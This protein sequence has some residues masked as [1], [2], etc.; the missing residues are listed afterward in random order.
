M[1]EKYAVVTGASTGLGKEIA[2]NIASRG[3]NTILVAL[4]GEN[5]KDVSEMC[6]AKGTDSVCFELDLTDFNAL[7]E[8]TDSINSS[9]KVFALIN[10]AGFGGSS[11]L[12]KVPFDYIRTMI[13]LNAGAT[14]L[15]T[16]QLLDNM[17]ENDKSYVLN[18]SSMASLIP[19]GCKTV[20]PAS[21]AFVRYFSVGLREE[22]RGTGMSVSVAIPGPMETKPE[23]IARIRKHRHSGKLLTIPLPQIAEKCVSGM[24]ARKRTIVVGL[25]NKFSSV[26]LKFVPER[27]AAKM[28]TRSVKKEFAGK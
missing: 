28:M 11:L 9:Y 27:F 7:K 22:V 8:M 26:A 15:M 16:K 25:A 13:Q 18:I 24:F 1:G 5:L 2:L 3:I 21:K 19:C 23:I 6:R 20:Y 14:A 4:P 12:T 17:L 10:N